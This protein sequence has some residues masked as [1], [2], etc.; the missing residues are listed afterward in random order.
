M[1]SFASNV[2][3][4]SMKEMERLSKECIQLSEDIDNMEIKIEEIISAYNNH[5][6]YI[7]EGIE[8]SK[9]NI[10]IV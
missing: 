9:Y 4:I 3:H 6:T 1:I 5:S 7:S 2:S 10:V 8:L